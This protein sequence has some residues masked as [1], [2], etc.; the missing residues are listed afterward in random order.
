MV[1]DED[2]YELTGDGYEKEGGMGRVSEMTCK[3]SEMAVVMVEIIKTLP[4]LL[5]R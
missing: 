3:I 2:S 5:W 1:V 4:I